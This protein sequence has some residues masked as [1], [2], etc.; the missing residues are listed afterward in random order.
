MPNVDE[1]AIAMIAGER[2]RAALD[3]LPEPQR[4]CSVEHAEPGGP[5]RGGAGFLGFLAG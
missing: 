5:P 4:A 1:V 3:E 2:V